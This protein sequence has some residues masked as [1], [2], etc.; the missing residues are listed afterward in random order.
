[1]FRPAL[2]A[3]LMATSPRSS[4]M[5]LS[6][7]ALGLSFVLVGRSATAQLKDPIVREQSKETMEGDYLAMR[8]KDAEK[9][10]KKALETCGKKKCSKVAKAQLHTD[11]AVVYIAGLKKPDKGKQQL[12]EALKLDPS[13][14]VDPNYSTPEVD[15]AFLAVGGVKE[16]PMAEAKEDAAMAAE[17][18]ENRREAVAAAVPRNWFSLSFQQELLLHGALRGVCSG[19]EQYE[20][21][22]G[23]ASYR[24]VY[25]EAGNELASGVGLATRRVLFGYERLFWGRV[26]AGARV[27]FAFGG[28]PN[29]TIGIHPGFNPLHGEL[30]GSYWFGKAPFERKG[31][32]P[33][34]GL[35]VGLGEVNGKATVQV[36]PSEQHFNVGSSIPVDAWRKAGAGFVS[37]H[38]GGA[39]ALHPRHALTL[40]LRFLQMLGKS[41]S[42]A[43]GSLGYAL[44]L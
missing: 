44:G 2:A 33:Y 34:A 22:R 3:R 21:F 5:S 38:A 37:I 11:L 31:L 27:G 42:G 41:A 24:V 12:K 29:A 6:A 30:R 25:P 23:E 36:Y 10:L 8:F 14:Q 1:M 32:R 18:R 35:A 26:S 9:K 39:Y 13:V 20:C 19:A 17:E 28:R 15:E 7:F 43:A 4:I 40:E 16:D